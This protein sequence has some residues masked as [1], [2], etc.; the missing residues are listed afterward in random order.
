MPDL[1]QSAA[2]LSWLMLLPFGLLYTG[3]SVTLPWVKKNVIWRRFPLS[4]PVCLQ[5]YLLALVLTLFLLCQTLKSI[6]EL[7]QKGSRWQGQAS[8]W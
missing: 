8:G 2:D 3:A 4:C 1:L 5:V 7:L 6:K